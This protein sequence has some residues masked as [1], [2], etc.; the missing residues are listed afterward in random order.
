MLRLVRM[1]PWRAF[2]DA[3]AL[4]RYPSSF[5]LSSAVGYTV[6][7]TSGGVMKLNTASCS[8]VYT[9]MCL[10]SFTHAKL[11]LAA[12]QFRVEH[13]VNCRTPLNRRLQLL[14][15]SERFF[16]VAE[17]G[18]PSFVTRLSLGFVQGPVCVNFGNSF[19]EV[20]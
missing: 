19:G 8:Y 9:L 3:N 10:N 18:R 14:E 20:H 7:Q 13:V 2:A 16:M 11:I 17:L 6:Q 5:H 12:A 4:L 1:E 15:K